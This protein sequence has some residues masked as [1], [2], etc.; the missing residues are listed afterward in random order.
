M[1]R[2]QLCRLHENDYKNA[3]TTLH[4][5]IEG[6]FPAVKGGVF[7]LSLVTH[8]LVAKRARGSHMNRT[9]LNELRW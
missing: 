7:P 1:G 4:R 2:F 6:G 3:L 5:E 8:V 9:R